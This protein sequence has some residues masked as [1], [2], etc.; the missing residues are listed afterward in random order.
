MYAEQ[1]D[2]INHRGETLYKLIYYKDDTKELSEYMTKAQ[3]K[4][5]GDKL[6][7]VADAIKAIPK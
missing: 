6:K 7:L 1:T 4:A 5:F 3:I 2:I